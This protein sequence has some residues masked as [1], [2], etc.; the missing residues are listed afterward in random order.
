MK[1]KS[2]P[3][4]FLYFPLASYGQEVNEYNKKYRE[5]NNTISLVAGVSY[6]NNSFGL[7]YE[8]E[9]FRLKPND[10]F[11]T[12]LFL[13]Y[14]WLDTS[15]SFTP[16]LI[17]INNDDDIKGKTKYFN[18]NFAF[19]LN[20]KLRQMIGYNQIKGLYFRD[21]RKYIDLLLN[22]SDESITDAYIQFP[23]A[24]YRSFKGETS[25][26]W[27][28][29]KE[30]Y[31]SYTNMTYKPAKND[32]VVITG[33][34]YQY[35]ILKDSDRAIY[36][37]EVIGSGE[38]GSATKDIRLALRTGAGIQRVIDSNWYAVVEFYPQLYYSKLIDEDFHEFNMGMN[39]NVRIGYDNGKWFVGAGTQLNW[40]NSSNSN[41]YSSTQ[42]Q[43]RAGI[44]LRFNAPQIV[45]RN[46]DKIDNILK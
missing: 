27:V 43:F 10:S 33:L 22:G 19:F 29:N 2:I 37:G 38:E 44:G 4:L 11:Y 6:L 40:V 24:N 8:R 21:T 17:K 3:Y 13:R 36:R 30:N 28:G 23:D 34:F 26:L 35:N 1:I 46:F 32:F 20:S 9:I 14:R 41:L 39:S 31:R 18:V 7:R 42:W 5:D 15:I 25:Y 12:E 16:K 45:N